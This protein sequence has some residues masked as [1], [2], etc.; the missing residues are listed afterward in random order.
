MPE[1][2]VVAPAAPATYRCSLL[3]AR[4]SA[5]RVTRSAAKLRS[6]VQGFDS[7]AERARVGAMSGADTRP[8]EPLAVRF[9]ER[10]RIALDRT[11]LPSGEVHIDGPA[12]RRSAAR[13]GRQLGAEQVDV[14]QAQAPAAIPG[15]DH[16]LRSG[17]LILSLFV[18][19]EDD[20]AGGACRSG[21]QQR[22]RAAPGGQSWQRHKQAS[23]S[24]GCML[25]L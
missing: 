16:A 24:V 15:R 4:S 20:D 5:I 9:Q 13:G 12:H 10:P 8:V 18:P 14:G 6:T 19:A 21:D 3:S 1:L 11:S 23:G 22:D 7:P 25:Q 2:G 17:A